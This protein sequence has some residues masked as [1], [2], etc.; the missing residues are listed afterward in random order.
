MCASNLSVR[1]KGVKRK[2]RDVDKDETLPSSLQGHPSLTPWFLQAAKYA[3]KCVR[4]RET[5]T[6]NDFII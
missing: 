5:I 3:A 2:F 1:I 4:D 6:R